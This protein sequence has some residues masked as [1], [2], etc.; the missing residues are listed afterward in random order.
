MNDLP[1]FAA[2]TTENLAKFA[3]DAYVKMQEQHEAIE[4]YQRDLKDAMA[5]LRKAMWENSK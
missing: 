3:A 1:N 4:Q 5:E 2:W